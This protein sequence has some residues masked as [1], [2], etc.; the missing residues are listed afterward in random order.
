MRSQATSPSG[1]ISVGLPTSACRGLSLSPSSVGVTPRACRNSSSTPSSSSRLRIC[2]LSEG[3]AIRSTS[4]ARETFPLSAIRHARGVTPTELGLKFYEHA[5]RILQEV[6]RAK[7]VMRS[8]RL[9][10]CWLSEG[11]AI[12]STSAARE[13]FPL[14]AICVK[15]RSCRRSMAILPGAFVKRPSEAIAG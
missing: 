15:Y 8:P 9:R 14:S 13:T 6:E 4:A 7:E 10:I 5:R 1:R 12:R 3:W 2:W 11:W